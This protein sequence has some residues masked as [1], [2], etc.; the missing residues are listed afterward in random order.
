MH[1]IVGAQLHVEG[2]V[3]SVDMMLIDAKKKQK[4]LIQEH[5]FIKYQKRWVTH[6]DYVLHV[7]LFLNRT[8]NPSIWNVPSTGGFI[9]I[10]HFFL[11]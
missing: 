9:Y 8:K 10:L 1:Y 11:E 7:Y 4:H 3:P 6:I 5:V 2:T